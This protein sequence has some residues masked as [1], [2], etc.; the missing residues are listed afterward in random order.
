MV[1]VDNFFY[2]LVRDVLIP[3]M[4]VLNEDASEWRCKMCRVQTPIEGTLKT[5]AGHRQT[6]LIG[7]AVRKI[8]EIENERNI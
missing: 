4:I 5:A 7:E 2:E 1:D 3:E 6:C 8:L